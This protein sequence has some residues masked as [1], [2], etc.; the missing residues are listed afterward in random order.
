MWKT[1][2]KKIEVIWSASADLI[3]PQIWLEY[4]VPYISRQENYFLVDLGIN[5]F[6]FFTLKRNSRIKP[7]KIMKRKLVKYMAKFFTE[8]L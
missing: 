8:V 3:W 5:Y 6:L 7:E 4:F 1:A 2:F